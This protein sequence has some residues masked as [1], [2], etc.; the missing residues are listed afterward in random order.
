MTGKEFK[1]NWMAWKHARWC[2]ESRGEVNAASSQ[3]KT[4]RGS[5]MWCYSDYRLGIPVKPLSEEV[6]W[7]E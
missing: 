3:Q 6:S 7:L 1:K 5:Q 2:S 4:E